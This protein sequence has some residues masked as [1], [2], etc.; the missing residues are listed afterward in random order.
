MTYLSTLLIVASI[1]Y[2]TASGETMEK[3]KT[4]APIENMANIIPLDPLLVPSTLHKR[5][6]LGEQTSKFHERTSETCASTVGGG[7]IATKDECV[8][9]ANSLGLASATSN[10]FDVALATFPSGCIV[11]VANGFI[12]FNADTSSAAK[13]V[14][15]S[16]VT[17]KCICKLVCPPSTYQ[18]LTL[19]SSCKVCDPGTFSIPGRSSCEY[20]STSCPVGTHASGA[21][22]CDLCGA[23]RYNG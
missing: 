9:A 17:L 6:Q 3:T 4:P 2:A 23:G 5:R 15:C 21:A 8:E 13:S 19:Q 18:D 20:D 1:F 11:N 14:V 10:I 12:L 22:A 7:S 16:S